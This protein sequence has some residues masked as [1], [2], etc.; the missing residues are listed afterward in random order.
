MDV[1]IYVFKFEGYI[2][3]SNDVYIPQIA[4]LTLGRKGSHICL[5][6]AIFVYIFLYEYVVL[7]GDILAHSSSNIFRTHK[8]KYQVT[9]KSASKKKQKEAFFS[10]TLV[11]EKI[12]HFKSKE[13]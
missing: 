9:I 2:R 10:T 5:K 7:S 12:H 8:H 1:H 4:R 11:S 6:R 13:F 3:F